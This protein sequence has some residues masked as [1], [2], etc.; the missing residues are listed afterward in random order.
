MTITSEIAIA[1]GIRAWI[2]NGIPVLELTHRCMP[3]RRE[4]YIPP[5]NAVTLVTRRIAEIYSDELDY[6]RVF[7]DGRLEKPNIAELRKTLIRDVATVDEQGN[8]V[9]LY[10]VPDNWFI[11]TRPTMS[12]EQ[13]NQEH[14]CMPVITASR[15]VYVDFNINQHV[16]DA[17]DFPFDPSLPLVRAW[18]PGDAWSAVVFMQVDQHGRVIVYETIIG[19]RKNIQELA[20]QVQNM[21]KTLFP[22]AREVRDFGDPAGNTHMGQLSYYEA[23][24]KLDINVNSNSAYG[25]KADDRTNHIRYLLITYLAGHPALIILNNRSNRVLVESFQM[26]YRYL[27]DGIGIDKKRRPHVDAMNA[28]EYG[29]CN[30]TQAPTT[31]IKPARRHK[32]T[33]TTANFGGDPRSHNRKYV[34]GINREFGRPSV[35]TK[36]SWY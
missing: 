23:L 28:L 35:S 6:A 4:E 32:S 18:D 7:V 24:R 34:K 8:N 36:R 26:E 15:L 31:R 2:N 1:D 3:E 16:Q 10:E 30:T 14:R 29:V 9:Q 17:K 27:K 21:T 5:D 12:K 20:Y 19:D 13:F 11:L 25:V 22:S 33:V